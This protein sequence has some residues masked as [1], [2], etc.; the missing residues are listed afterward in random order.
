MEYYIVDSENEETETQIEQKLYQSLPKI[1]FITFTLKPTK[2]DYDYCDQF[3]H[4]RNSIRDIMDKFECPYTAVVETTSMSNVHWHAALY[5]EC[6]YETMHKRLLSYKN[7]ANRKYVTDLKNIGVPGQE[8]WLG[9]LDLL[10]FG[11]NRENLKSYLQKQNDLVRI[12][13]KQGLNKN[14][15]P[16]LSD[17]LQIFM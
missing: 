12:V 1:W 13:L 2:Y 10:S 8:S 16:V 17:G 6:D 4:T 15:N 5:V 7:Q 9:T 11:S 14:V 3:L